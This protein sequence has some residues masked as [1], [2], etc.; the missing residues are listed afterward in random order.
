M[1][2]H[3]TL[4]VSRNRLAASWFRRRL[5][6]V[7]PDTTEGHYLCMLARRFVVECLRSAGRL[8]LRRMSRTFSPEPPQCFFPLRVGKVSDIRLDKVAGYLWRNGEKATVAHRCHFLNV[9]MVVLDESQMGDQGR[10]VLPAG[11]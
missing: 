7:G 1:G 8:K 11:E 3:A 6:V 10:K 2:T 9:H 5:A 4:P